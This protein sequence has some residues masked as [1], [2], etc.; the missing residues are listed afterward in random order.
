MNIYRKCENAKSQYLYKR[1]NVNIFLKNPQNFVDFSEIKKT[2]IGSPRKKNKTYIT[3]L[4]CGFDIETSKINELTYMYIWTF[5]I[6]DTRGKRIIIYGSYYEEFLQ[7]LETIQKITK[8]SE[9]EKIIIGVANLNYE[10]QF[11]KKWMN[12]TN[13]FFKAKR[14]IFYFEHNHNFKFIEMLNFNGNSLKKL[15]ENECNT[16]K[17]VGDL[18]YSITREK[19]PKLTE[20][21]INYCDN[22]VLIILDYLEK[23]YKQYILNHF[24]PVSIQSILREKMKREVFKTQEKPGYCLKNIRENFPDQELY[25]ILMQY[26]YRGGYVHSN[27]YYTNELLKNICSFD[28]TSAYPYYMLTGYVPSHFKEIQN[29]SKESFYNL[30][31]NDKKCWFA[32][33]KFY[34]LKQKYKHSIESV[35]KVLDS[36]KIKNDNGRI[37]SANYIEVY[38][39]EQD[40]TI[41]NLFYSWSHFEI[42]E[43]YE[44]TK[45][46]LPQYVINVL[47]QAYEKKAIL[48][49]AGQ[50]YS[51][52]KTIVN[53]CYGVMVTK[54][55]LENLKYNS[56]LNIFE[57][58]INSYSKAT[59]KA[60][61]LPQWGVWITSG[62]RLYLLSTVFALIQNGTDIVYCDTDSIKPLH[63]EKSIDYIRLNNKKVD[64]KVKKACD[65]YKL[66]Y[67]KIKGLGNFDFEGHIK[68][69]KTL[70]CKRY[71]YIDDKNQFKQVIAGLPKKTLENYKQQHPNINLFEYFSN[72]M[73]FETTDKLISKYIEDDFVVEVNS[74]KYYEKSCLTLENAPF[75]LT[76]ADI[77]ID[78]LLEKYPEEKE[79]RIL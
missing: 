25:N 3:N 68:K 75:K 52:E 20:T 9:N 32:R 8:L 14:H 39:N 33:I 19:N 79:K 43:L 28:I 64:E 78:L 35:S 48:K 21:E 34:N 42:I 51:F 2:Y 18:D 47:F 6:L 27:Y 45:I 46:K 76:L 16:Q 56:D 55:N 73:N 23:Y 26:L 38:I 44:S 1:L 60:I 49:E 65:F 22:D 10:F 72:Y 30:N 7:L 67:S 66:D 4:L 11:L 71:I 61:L 12:V 54:L 5:G 58:E 70:G 24:Q 36:S 63:Y 41:Y 13:S 40:F 15:A 62:I 53:S 69:F 17:C 59:K 74:E 31:Q 50:D 29:I 57:T 77:Y 37:M